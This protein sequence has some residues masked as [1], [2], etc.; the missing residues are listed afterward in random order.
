MVRQCE[1]HARRLAELESVSVGPAPSE[2][3]IEQL[4]RNREEAL[5]LH[6]QLD[7]AEIHVVLHAKKVVEAKAAIDDKAA[8]SVSIARGK[9]QRWKIRQHGEISIGELATLHISR[10]QED[11]VLKEIARRCAELDRDYIERLKAAEASSIDALVERRHQRQGILKEIKHHRDALARGAPQGLPAQQAEL[12][13]LRREENAILARRPELVG[14][15]PSLS[16]MEKRK[17]EFDKREAQLAAATQAAKKANLD[18]NQALL[19]EQSNQRDLEKSIV[20]QTAEMRA[21]KTKVG[22]QDRATLAAAAEEAIARLA[23]AQAKV[24]EF[25]LSDADQALEARSNAAVHAQRQRAMRVR[26]NEDLMLRLQT[27][28][29]G[30]EGLHQKRIQAEQTL[31]EFDRNSAR[32]IAGQ[33]PSAF[34][35]AV[36]GNP[37]GPGARRHRPDQ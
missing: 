14:W 15:A 21:L 5:K 25:A 32:G 35:R 2:Q 13:R 23:E 34:E 7:A 4:R 11:Q 28:L 8:K 1:E 26:E 3:E 6:A 17:A 27:Q 31:A 24:D 19:Q 10:G 12:D 29:D 33:R 18:A 20:E 16:E 22:Q 36:R 30:A 9:E 37:A